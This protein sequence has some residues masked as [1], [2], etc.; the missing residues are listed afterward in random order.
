MKSKQE[1][2]MWL[3]ETVWPDGHTSHIADPDKAIK[4]MERLEQWIADA[5]DTSQEP[6]KRRGRPPKVQ[7]SI[8]EPAIADTSDQ[9]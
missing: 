6:A 1:L 5:A 4:T 9:A 7:E 2:R 3:I 8:N